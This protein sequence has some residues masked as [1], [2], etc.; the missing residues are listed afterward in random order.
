MTPPTIC[1]VSWARY[2]TGV[3]FSR[4]INVLGLPVIAM[5]KVLVCM[6]KRGAEVVCAVRATGRYLCMTWGCLCI[7]AP[8]VFIYM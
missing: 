8:V 2:V 5:T 7:R 6:F 1:A 4:I 3:A